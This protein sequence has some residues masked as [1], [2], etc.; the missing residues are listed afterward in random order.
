MMG[1]LANGDFTKMSGNASWS[2]GQNLLRVSGL[3]KCLDSRGM[4]DQ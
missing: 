2:M 4:I 1:N 3:W